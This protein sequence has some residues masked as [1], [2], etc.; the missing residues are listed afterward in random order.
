M[1]FMLACCCLWLFM[2][3]HDH[4]WFWMVKFVIILGTICENPCSK[5][6]LEPDLSGVQS[7]GFCS[8]DC[9]PC[10]HGFCVPQTLHIIGQDLTWGQVGGNMDT[11]NQRSNFSD[12]GEQGKLSLCLG[13]PTECDPRSGGGGHPAKFH[14]KNKEMCNTYTGVGSWAEFFSPEA[15]FHQKHFKCPI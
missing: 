4:L 7:F 8:P 12:G 1:L 11:P 3:I 15:H 10:C 2:N 6:E 5:S 14:V 13:Q 9:S